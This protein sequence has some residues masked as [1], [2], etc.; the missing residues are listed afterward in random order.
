MV[1]AMPLPVPILGTTPIPPGSARFHPVRTATARVR[2]WLWSG[3][4]AA[5]CASPGDESPAEPWTL[6]TVRADTT[7]GVRV[8]VV[9]DMEGLSGQTEPDTY[10]FG[11][12]AY[13]RGQELLAADVNAVIEGLY[14]GG[15]TEVHVVD[16]HGSG[17]PEPDLRRDLLDERAEQVVRDEPFDAYSDLAARGAYD[18]VVVVG[19]HAKAGSGGYAAHTYGLGTEF[20]INGRAIT[21]TELVGLLWGR[22]DV[23]VIFASGDDRLGENLETM[24]WIEYVTVKTAVHPDSAVLRPVAEARAALTAGAARAIRGLIEGRAM[25]MRVS[26]PI[27]AALGATPPA[28]LSVLEDVPGVPF[29][30]DRVTFTADSM[31]EAYGGLVALVTVASREYA[32][33]LFETVMSHPDSSEIMDAFV[34]ALDRRWFEVESGRWEEPAEGP[35]PGERYHGYR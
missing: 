4:I 29:A 23:P 21:E 3:L 5:A 15:A 18:A 19:M 11:R 12:E 34:R 32:G 22:V 28:S 30:D 9:H 6:S 1:R 35:P 13:A 26:T 17:N 10:I 2:L 7:D 14:A 31:R 24:P 16:G 33:L 25:A 27:T 20:V 8:L